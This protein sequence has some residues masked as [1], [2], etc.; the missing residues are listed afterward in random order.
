M[1]SLSRRA[2]SKLMAAATLARQARAGVMPVRTLGKIGFKAGILGFGAQYL[3]GTAQ[4]N[5]DR[6]IAEGLEAGMNYVDIAP[7]YG[8]S[9]DLLGNALR[10]KRDKVFLATKIEEPT[11]EGALTEVRNSLRRLQTNHLDCVL[12]HNI[13]RDERWTDIDKLL[14]KGGAL[15]GL[16]EARKQGMIRHIGCSTHTNPAR[17]IRAFDTGEIDL[18]QAILNFVD[19][20]IYHLEERLLPEACKRNMAIVAMKVLGGPSGETGGCRIS[21]EDRVASMRYVWG[22]PGV[23]VSIIG[24]RKPAE[25]REG[26]DAALGY[27]PLSAAELAALEQR[28]KAIA[29]KW[30]PSRG[31]VT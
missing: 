11:R 31:P 12:F 30:G 5:V 3:A 13:A 22:I 26:L 24:F 18:M 6:V 23:A 21:A 29:E 25:L 20:Q 16:V 28:G 27:Q 9:E 2:F 4:A 10:G 19:H 1:T 14:A 15:E 8:N 17:V 7:N